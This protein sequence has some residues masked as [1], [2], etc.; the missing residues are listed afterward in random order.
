MEPAPFGPDVFWRPKMPSLGSGT[1]GEVSRYQTVTGQSV[2][3]LPGPA[4]IQ[5][6]QSDHMLFRCWKQMAGKFYP[7]AVKQSAATDRDLAAKEAAN[8]VALWGVPGVL[9]G[10]GVVHENLEQVFLVSE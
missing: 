4:S 10:E 5:N 2:Q 8:L 6:A 1:T 9:Q 3:S 7:K